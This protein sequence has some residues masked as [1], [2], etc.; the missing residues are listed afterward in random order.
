LPCSLWCQDANLGFELRATLTG[1]AVRSHEL[2]EPPRNGN[3]ATAGARAVLYPSLKL[4]RDWAI[5]GAV[6]IYS[7]P[8]FIEQFY[9]QGYG[10]KTDVLQAALTY[11]RFWSDKSLVVRMGQLPSAFGSFLLRYDDAANPLI[12]MPL[13]YGY[14]YK[15]VSSLGLPGAQADFTTGKLDARLQFTNSSPANRRS[16]AD[17]DQY[18]NWTAGAGYTIKQGL[19]IGGSMY[20]GPYL[21]REHLYYHPG[22]AKPADLPASGYGLDAQWGHGHWTVEGELQRFQFPYRAIPTFHMD[23]GYT[24][25]RHVLH[26]R[27]YVAARAGYVRSGSHTCERAFESAIGIRPAAHHLI[28]IGH[29]NSTFAVQWITTLRAFSIGR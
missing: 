19:R 15:P 14:Y 29:Q 10:V 16:I 8:F 1:A 7:R 12:D 3:S 18:G 21:H 17:K 26:P 22:E 25:V 13:S 9:S 24:E 6:Q 4:H 2:T 28:K 11:S 27:L 20:R 23:A 5:T